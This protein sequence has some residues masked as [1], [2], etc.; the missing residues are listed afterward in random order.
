MNRLDPVR[1]TRL[2]C[3]TI[4]IGET[5]IRFLNISPPRTQNHA[6]LAASRAVI[7]NF[8]NIVGLP[9]KIG[10]TFSEDEDKVGAPPVVVLSDHL[11]QRAFNR[12]PSVIGRSI[13]LHDQNYMVIGVMPPQVT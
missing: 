3:L 8:F 13:T 2:R 7:R 11:W 6:T 10:R 1:I 12:D 9:P 5:T 4:S